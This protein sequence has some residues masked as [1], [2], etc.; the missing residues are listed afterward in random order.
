MAHEPE[1]LDIVQELTPSVLAFRSAE[2]DASR[3]WIFGLGLWVAA[4]AACATP[5]VAVT[6]WHPTTT[7]TLASIA[8]G[9]QVL[10]FGLQ[11]TISDAEEAQHALA[12]SQTLEQLHE[13][14]RRQAELSKSRLLFANDWKIEA[15]QARYQLTRE[16]EFN[17]RFT[18]DTFEPYV[19]GASLAVKYWPDHARNPNVVLPPGG[20]PGGQPVSITV[21]R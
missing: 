13:I 2:A 15:E 9:A 12:P 7:W 19:L 10:V 3:G 6:P 8:V 14:E 4:F 20:G 5:S 1:A 16:V 11:G 21:P 17:G 18:K